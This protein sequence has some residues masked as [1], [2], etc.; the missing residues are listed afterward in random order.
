MGYG[1]RYTNVDPFPPDVAFGVVL[2]DE[3]VA[4]VETVAPCPPAVC[5][6]TMDRVH[7]FGSGNITPVAGGWAIVRDASTDPLNF[8]IYSNGFV[9][10]PFWLYIFPIME[11]CG[12][13]VRAF[14]TDVSGEWSVITYIFAEDVFAFE[15]HDGV[16]LYWEFITDPELSVHHTTVLQW[17]IDLTDSPGSETW[18]DFGPAIH[19]NDFIS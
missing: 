7:F 14:L 13:R 12:H 2:D 17:Q 18:T 9:F 16:L 5:V 4:V 15:D 10:A 8:N 19:I 3:Q 6:P 1:P 11:K